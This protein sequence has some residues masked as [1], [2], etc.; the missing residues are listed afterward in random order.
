[1]N[2]DQTGRVE[3]H[4]QVEQE[5]HPLL[6]LR[7]DEVFVGRGSQK[8]GFH[9]SHSGLRVGSVEGLLHH[10]LHSLEHVQV[11]LGGL[12]AASSPSAFGLTDGLLRCSCWCRGRG[13]EGRAHIPRGLQ[14][15]IFPPICQEVC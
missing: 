3:L 12:F 7:D 5:V 11:V 2:R 6:G 1:M 13:A 8:A 4:R 15:W 10:R 14:C 9:G